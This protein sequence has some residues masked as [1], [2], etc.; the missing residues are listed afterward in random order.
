[1]GDFKIYSNMSN[2]DFSPLIVFLLLE[3]ARRIVYA[4]L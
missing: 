1:M 4:L 2:L 3:F